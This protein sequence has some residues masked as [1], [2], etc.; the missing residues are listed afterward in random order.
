[1]DEGRVSPGAPRELGAKSGVN[2][3]LNIIP[4]RSNISSLESRRSL[5]VEAGAKTGNLHDRHVLDRS[6]VSDGLEGLEVLHVVSHP[7]GGVVLHGDIQLLHAFGLSSNGADG[8]VNIVFGFHKGFVLGFN[9]MHN[10][11]SVNIR[12]PFL[13]VDFLKQL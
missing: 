3:V 12:L 6:H 2:T 5:N 7:D 1:M 13:P 10:V 9:L 11:L 8:S 4:S